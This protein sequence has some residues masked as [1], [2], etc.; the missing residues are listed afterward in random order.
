MKDVY[1][2][3]STHKKQ[4][5]FVNLLNCGAGFWMSSTGVAL[6]RFS[7]VHRVN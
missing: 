3:I 7:I 1:I 5:I 2:F 6:F 4:M